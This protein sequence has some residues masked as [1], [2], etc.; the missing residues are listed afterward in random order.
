VMGALGRKRPSAMLRHFRAMLERLSRPAN[1][2]AVNQPGARNDAVKDANPGSSQTVPAAILGPA[3]VLTQDTGGIDIVLWD[4]GIDGLLQENVP[5][6]SGRKGPGSGAFWAA[7]FLAS[8]LVRTALSERPA[9]GSPSEQR[10][11]PESRE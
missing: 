6:G 8:G 7:A 4:H 1:P 3:P 9:A 5:V 10:P 11:R 2:A